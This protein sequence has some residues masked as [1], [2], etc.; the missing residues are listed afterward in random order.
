VAHRFLSVE[1]ID[2]VR[3]IRERHA[4]DGAPITAAVKLNLIVNDTP[5]GDEPLHSYVDST[6][7]TLVFELGQL[8]EPDVTVTT[9]YETA[10]SLFV[11]NDP[12]VGMQAFMAGKLLVRGDMMKLLALPMLAA[13]DPA[14][15]AA[16][17]EI[18]TITA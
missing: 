7:G 6:S 1:W 10:R 5:F 11:A 2:A 13:S 12:A 14:A 17:A 15:Q 16:S 18:R 3:A 4:A 9:D 8:E